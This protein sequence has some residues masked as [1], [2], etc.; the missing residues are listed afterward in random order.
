MPINQD[1]Q[2][3]KNTRSAMQNLESGRAPEHGAQRCA[4]RA[5]SVSGTTR[6]NRMRDGGAVGRASP[7]DG[8]HILILV[9]V[10]AVDS[11]LRLRAA[12]DPAE[13][14]HGDASTGTDSH[15]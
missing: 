1:V 13:L 11:M 7:P 15:R 8:A 6:V 10:T 14:T 5:R 12:D 4:R 9:T 3:S 2:Q